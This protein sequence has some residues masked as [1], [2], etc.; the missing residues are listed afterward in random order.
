MRKLILLFFLTILPL[1]ASAATKVEIDGIYYY[2]TSGDKNTAEVTSKASGGYSGDIVIPASVTY[3]DVA[4]GVT[5]IGYAAF[6]WCT[7]LTSVT[8]PNSVTSIGERAFHSCSGLTSV[9]IP[10]SVT[11]IGYRA[12]Y[13]CSSLT[14]VT[15]PNSVISI[16]EETFYYCSG[17]TS[18]TIPNSVTSIGERAFHSCSSLT[19]VTIPNSVTSI[20]EEAFMWCSGLTSV[21]I[22]NSVTSIGEM[23]FMWC[24]GLTS[25]TIGNSVTSIGE[26]AFYDCSG[27]TSVTIPNSVTSIGEEAFKGCSG[28]TSVTIPNNVTSIGINAF[29]SCRSLNKVEFYCKT[30]DSWFSGF[31]SIKE[32]TI[33]N[34]VT[35]IGGS[36]FKDCSGLT[37]VTIPNSVTSIGDEAFYWCS[38][39]TSVTIGNSVTSIGD[40]AFSGCSG[41]TSIT[42]PNCVTSIGDGAFWSCSSL[43]SVTIPNSVI[44]IGDRAFYYCSGLTSVTIG[45]SVTSIGDRAFSECSG[46]TS[47]TIPNSVTSIGIAAFSECSHLTSVTIPNSVTSIGSFAFS[48]CSGL[49]SVSIGNSVTSIGKWAFEDCSGLISVTIPNSVTSISDCAFDGCS[50]LT[51]VIIPNSVTSIGDHAFW[52]CFYLKNLY[53]LAADVPTMVK[54]AF[55]YYNTVTL[56]VL[57]GC[58]EKYAAVEPWK[59]FKEIKEITTAITDSSYD[60]NNN[61]LLDDDDLKSL[62]DVIL[63]R[64]NGADVSSIVYDANND[65]KVD[66]LDIVQLIGLSNDLKEGSLLDIDEE[67]E[68]GYEDPTETEQE[69]MEMKSNEDES[70]VIVYT[71]EETLDNEALAREVISLYDTDDDSDYFDTEM[72]KTRGTYDDLVKEA[73]RTNGKNIF[74]DEIDIEQQ[75]R[76][77]KNWGNTRYG[78]FK[79]FYNTREEDYV[80]YLYVVFYYKGGFPNKK[81]AYLKLGQLNSGKIIS[82]TTIS[83]GQE[84]AILRVCIDKYIP[85]HG[86]FNVFPLLITEESKARNY[87]NPILVKSKQIIDKNWRNKY[88]GYEFGK[89][90]GVSVYFNADNKKGNNNMGDGWHQCVEL[91]KRYVKQLNSDIKRKETDTWGNAINW[92]YNR[93]NETKDPNKYLVFANDGS[94]RVREGDLLVWKHGDYGHIGVVISVKAD[95]ISVAH[96]NGG[97]GTYASPIGTS[98]KLVNGVIKDIAPGTNRSPIFK[99]IQPVT[100]FIRIDNPNEHITSYKASMTASTT[101]IA[102]TSAQVGKSIT[103]T[104]I[105]N[106]PKGKETLEISS[107]T[108]SRGDVF[109]VDVTNCSIEPGDAKVVRVTFTPS[110]SGEYK[111]KIIIKSDANDNPTWAI[112]LSGSGKDN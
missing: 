19:S 87:Q 99:S 2:L 102:F 72:N 31:G 103:H 34:S 3:K 7:D 107:I 14:S 26:M 44:S 54:N 51:S 1:T 43:T 76:N 50:G 86:C 89:I 81:T 15:I 112:R 30:I 100:H 52:G 8:I 6:E 33:G 22:G 27:L 59:N 96:Q 24:S 41:L 29:R 109:S 80:R 37:S 69:I 106:N 71:D 23:A 13:H 94:E 42:I 63:E 17:L 58:V 4:Y 101:N 49:T 16:G 77:L 38:G 68:G 95:R 66:I 85:G 98:M 111:D 45:N 88:Y 93:K 53:C 75:S 90:N 46:L 39:L 35:S 78:G 9:T 74:D 108:L 56:H 91:C 84:S 18:V 104:F 57:A 64:T 61:G 28:L 83:P 40:H 110:A 92:P 97:T 32:I 5:S 70:S 11:S 21:T 82:S 79:V 73:I 55:D 36:A 60:V 67:N 12:F 65:G 105:I 48:G 20:G 62:L 25:V 47:V 10:N